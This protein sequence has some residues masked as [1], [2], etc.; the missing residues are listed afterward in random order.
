MLRRATEMYNRQ[1]G[2]RAPERPLRSTQIAS[3]DSAISHARVIPSSIIPNTRV[4][5]S[6][7]PPT[8]STSTD[9]APPPQ[10][11]HIHHHH[12]HHH[13]HQHAPRNH[14]HT[15]SNHSALHPPQASNSYSTRYLLKRRFF[16]LWQ[17]FIQLTANPS[18]S[19]ARSLTSTS[20]P[21]VA[22]APHPIA[23]TPDII[24]NGI[25][26]TGFSYQGYTHSPSASFAFETDLL[27]ST[28]IN[29]ACAPDSDSLNTT[30]PPSAN[31]PLICINL[32][33]PLRPQ[34]V[35]D[36]ILTHQILMSRTN[37]PL[38][39]HP[40]MMAHS[41]IHSQINSP[42]RIRRILLR[43]FA[44][45]RSAVPFQFSLIVNPYTSSL[46]RR[47][48]TR[49]RSTILTV[50]GP[51]LPTS[52]APSFTPSSSVHTPTH[53][54]ALDELHPRI[55]VG[56]PQGSPLSNTV[57]VLSYAFTLWRANTPRAHAHSLRDINSMF[58]LHASTFVPILA[59]TEFTSIM[60][61]MLMSTSL[62][63][64]SLAPDE[65]PHGNEHEQ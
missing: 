26:F 58:H 65:E 25:P 55:A 19:C 62:M 9:H 14:Q 8:S 21:L 54:E 48:F 52:S 17:S 28:S 49:W 4:P 20:P 40:R 3:C 24:A 33:S 38:R 60:D 44:T 45:W 16:S 56:F 61:L 22:S 23:L 57:F 39:C 34:T 36:P 30:P 42:C 5:T 12:H 37:R 18:S 1:R 43:F 7:T 10:I 64:P 11:I 31:S 53:R 15:Q 50:D 63:P 27:A 41:L 46:K 47:F 59:T 35:T 51:L 29:I 6:A 13:Y 2:A 32:P